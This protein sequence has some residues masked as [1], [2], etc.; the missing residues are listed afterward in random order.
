MLEYVTLA[1]NVA[2]IVVLALAAWQASS[3][4]L[5]GFGLDSLIE[6]GA[7]IVV[8]WEL[9]G[10]GEARQRHAL[11]LIG[12]AFVILAIYLTVQSTVALA[13]NHHAS[14]SPAGI[15]WS[16]VSAV[17]MFA[18]AIGKFRTGTALGKPVLVTKGRGT[19]V[20][21]LLALAVLISLV[22]TSLLGWW[23]TD[24][25]AGFVLVCHAAREATHIFR[26]T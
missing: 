16:A 12:M 9:S 23:W 17:A 25:I 4:A 22:F 1:W 13:T 19:A 15:V 14:A 21:G 24:P 3:V 6:I 11:R 5:L 26:A 10:S 18:L 2:G 7:S 20:D 8:V